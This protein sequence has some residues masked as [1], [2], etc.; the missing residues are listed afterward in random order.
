MNDKKRVLLVKR[1]NT[2]Q[3]PG[4][5]SL[6]GGTKRENETLEQCLIRE[7]REEL[8]CLTIKYSFF[9]SYKIKK[10]TK[11]II[12]NYY[13][14]LIRGHIKINKQELSDYQ[15]LAKKDLLDNLAYNQNKVL[16]DF[17]KK[18]SSLNNKRKVKNGRG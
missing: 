1:A 7:I 13:T 4:L 6:P 17:F 16:L 10:N 15:W 12:A 5:W 3:E 11:T 18:G 8:G 14:G 2:V 9:K